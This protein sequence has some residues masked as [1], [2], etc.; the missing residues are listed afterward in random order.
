MQPFITVFCEWIQ[1]SAAY[2]GR[3]FTPLKWPQKRDGVE[4]GLDVGLVVGY[5]PSDVEYAYGLVYGNRL[6]AAPTDLLRNDCS[7]TVARGGNV[8]L[9][10]LCFGLSLDFRGMLES[11]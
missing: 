7:E 1:C 6:D 4:R 5:A 9:A 3:L 2:H 8:I 10:I 11:S